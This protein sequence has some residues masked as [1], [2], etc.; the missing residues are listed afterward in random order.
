MGE[1]KTIGVGTINNYS[2][3]NIWLSAVSCGYHHKNQCG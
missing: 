3:K 1:F 2:G